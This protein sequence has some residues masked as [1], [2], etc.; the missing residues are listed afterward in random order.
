MQ[1]EAWA[2]GLLTE[3]LPAPPRASPAE[4]ESSLALW[5]EAPGAL[6]TFI[7]L[8]AWRCRGATELAG[9]A[10]GTAET[11][12]SPVTRGPPA[13]GG[14]DGRLWPSGLGHQ[15][16]GPPAAEAVRKGLGRPPPAA[17]PPSPSQG[18]PT[19]PLLRLRPRDSQHR[20]GHGIPATT[21]PAVLGEQRAAVLSTDQ[22]PT[23]CPPPCS[24]GRAG[25]GV[26]PGAGALG[27]PCVAAGRP[28]LLSVRAPS[29]R[30]PA[31][32]V[33]RLARA[34]LSHQCAAAGFRDPR[35]QPTSWEVPVDSIPD[36]DALNPGSARLNPTGEHTAR[37]RGSAP[38]PRPARPRAP[39][40]PPLPSGGPSGTSSPL[41]G[42]P[43]DS[44]GTAPHLGAQEAAPTQ[45]PG[46]ARAFPPAPRPH[47]E[48]VLPRA[49]SASLCPVGAGPLPARPA[50]TGNIPEAFLKLGG[51]ARPRAGLRLAPPP[52]PRDPGRGGGP[53]RALGGPGRKKGSREKHESRPCHW[54]ALRFPASQEVWRA[55]SGTGRG[56]VRPAPAIFHRASSSARATS[57]CWP[58]LRGTRRAHAL[59][60]P[61]KRFQPT[62]PEPGLRSSNWD[63]EPGLFLALARLQEGIR[64]RDRRRSQA[65][66]RHRRSRQPRAHCRPAAELAAR[67]GRAPPPPRPPR[68]KFRSAGAPEGSAA[69][70]P[71][72]RP[73]PRL[74]APGRACPPP[75]QT[76]F[77]ASARFPGAGGS[78]RRVPA[79]GALGAPSGRKWGRCTRVAGHAVGV[80]RFPAPA[81]G[82]APPPAALQRSPGRCSVAGLGS[83]PARR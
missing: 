22:A 59:P 11:R 83:E 1:A 27:A 70:R 54:A 28:A 65:V 44:W 12:A 46:P 17:Q 73:G 24:Q 78:G 19:L 79:R 7:R 58:G 71:H 81:G 56:E 82:R 60:L 53:G 18:A 37:Q 6:G 4:P 51:P 40:S 14:S 23:R 2:F 13:P 35:T 3:S 16:L 76:G 36:R 38:P 10:Q 20:P 80:R 33:E 55:A 47:R 8:L 30:R 64:I 25:R 74:R 41:L 9:G 32:G 49:P 21:L 66:P 68:E 48:H 77:A 15:G 5:L 34:G 43:G 57:L 26:D 50:P 52:P 45:P 69:P 67:P 72:L 75:P 63:S 62:S 31:S 42:R 29:A 39:A 61:S